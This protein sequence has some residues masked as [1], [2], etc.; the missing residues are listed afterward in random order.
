MFLGSTLGKLL[1][2]L[3]LSLFIHEMEVMEKLL[4]DATCSIHGKSSINVAVI[5][6]Q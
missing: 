2:S 4:K 6:R 1:G 5:I 3:Y